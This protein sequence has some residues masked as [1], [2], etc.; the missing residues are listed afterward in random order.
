M[1]VRRVDAIAGLV[2]TVFGAAALT[3]SWRMPRFAER[4]IDPLT[5]PGITPGLLSAIILV[6]GIALM[7]RGLRGGGEDRNPGIANWDRAS[8]LRTGFTIGAIVVYG[9]GLFGQVPFVPA[10]AG[11]IFVFTF[12]AEWMRTDR[13]ASLARTA[14]GAAVLSG[15]ATIAIWGVF[16]KLFLVTLPG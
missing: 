15:V 4:N 10:T 6:L 12:I 13:T 1:S 14:L 16:T 3:A 11:F 8:A 9:I 2:V 7:L 5:A